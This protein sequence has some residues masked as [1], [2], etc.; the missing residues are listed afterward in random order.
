[1]G[2]S[3]GI[4]SGDKGLSRR[5]LSWYW[6]QQLYDSPLPKDADHK[7]V[8]WFEPADTGVDLIVAAALFHWDLIYSQNN[9]STQNEFLPLDTGSQASGM[10][11]RTPGKR[12][13]RNALN[14]QT[15]WLRQIK[16]LCE[17]AVDKKTFNPRPERFLLQQ[18]PSSCV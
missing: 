12:P 9:I 4:L 1:M 18:Q 2:S 13:F 10:Y 17:I 3:D 5:K 7:I 6:N 14:E 15:G 16:C 8:S 11:A